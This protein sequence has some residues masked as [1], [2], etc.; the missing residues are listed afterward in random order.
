MIEMGFE[1]LFIR[2]WWLIFPIF[3]ML[4]YMWDLA[5]TNRRAGRAMDLIKT[6]V[7]QGKEPPAELLDIA[8][9]GDELRD[10]FEGS[11][12]NRASSSAWSLVTFTAIAVGFG[13]ATQ[14]APTEN[15]RTAFTIV[16]LVMGVLAIG[17]FFI[18]FFGPRREK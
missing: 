11:R 16:A 12:R 17:S 13:A 18:L 10:G 15:A 9:G 2:F 14:F 3:G 7:E 1:E 8:A 4:I 6:Y 5:A